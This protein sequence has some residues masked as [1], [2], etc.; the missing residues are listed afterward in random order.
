MRKA[1]T[2]AEAAALVKM[3][4]Q[5]PEFEFYDVVADPFELTNLVEQ[6]E[7]AQKIAL[8]KAKLDAWMEQQ[9]DKGNETELAVKAH[10]TGIV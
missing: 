5:R 6:P 8:L 4:Q 10:K 9:G 7:H 1:K 3:Y 2:D